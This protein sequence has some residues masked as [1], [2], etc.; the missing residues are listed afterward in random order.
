MDG[1]IKNAVPRFRLKFHGSFNSKNPV[2]HEITLDTGFTGFVSMPLLLAFPLGLILGGT[3]NSI[4]ADGRTVTSMWAMGTVIIEGE[5]YHGTFT[6]SSG[7]DILVG[8]DF[9]KKS[10]RVLIVDPQRNA[11]SV[12]K[13]PTPRTIKPSL[14]PA[15]P[16]V[17]LPPM[18]EKP[19]SSK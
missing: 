18:A 5:S 12:I 1:L 3:I 14:P 17:A 11:L 6:L 13:S 19:Q 8:M 9:L 10:G 15:T 16:Q 7:A 4:L 2:E